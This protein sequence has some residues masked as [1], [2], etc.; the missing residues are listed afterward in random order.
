M[1]CL[2]QPSQQDYKLTLLFA[3]ELISLEMSLYND[4]P[5]VKIQHI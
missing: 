2:E 4:A 3:L 1:G 5:C